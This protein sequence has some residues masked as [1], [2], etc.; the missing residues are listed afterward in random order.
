MIPTDTKTIVLTA[1]CVVLVTTWIGLMARLVIT[2]KSHMPAGPL[3]IAIALET[4]KYG[5]I[6]AVCVWAAARWL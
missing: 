5:L 3:L 6:L 1:I 2:D 4:A